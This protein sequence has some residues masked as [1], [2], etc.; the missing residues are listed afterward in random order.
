MNQEHVGH[1][2]IVKRWPLYQRA[3]RY[4]GCK[5]LTVGYIISLLLSLIIMS[6]YKFYLENYE[7]LLSD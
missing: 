3:E 1:V 5:D 2:F 4:L 6:Y 7:Y